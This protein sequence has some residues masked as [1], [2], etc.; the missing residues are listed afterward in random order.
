MALEN[1]AVLP[2][3]K[4]GITFG[5]ITG[6]AMVIYN[7]VLRVTHVP[8]ASWLNFMVLVIYLIGVLWFCFA[9]SKQ[10]EQ[11]TSFGGMF[12]A[13]FRMVAIVTILL[14]AAA[15]INVWVDPGLKKEIMAN[16]LAA[17]KA[18]KKSQAEIDEAMKISNDNFTLTV[19]MASVFSNIF[20]GVVFALVGAGIFR[21]SK[22]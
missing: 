9:F 4:L 2:S 5:L 7:I 17:L 22:V 21:K 8:D 12:K 14:V 18:A 16:N 1:K 15:L 10:E 3:N 20:Y 19:V 13:G 6:L 11:D